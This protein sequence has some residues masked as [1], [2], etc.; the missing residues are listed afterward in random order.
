MY[1]DDNDVL[2]MHSC[3]RILF[4]R[5]RTE[6][7]DML[8]AIHDA[9]SSCFMRHNFP[10]LD[11]SAKS[12]LEEGEEPHDFKAHASFI[13]VSKAMAHAKSDSEK[14]LGVVLN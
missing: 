5:L 3:C 12:W 11:E 1:D 14:S 13:K 2:T 9:L 4:T 8:Q 10:V 6:P 7:H